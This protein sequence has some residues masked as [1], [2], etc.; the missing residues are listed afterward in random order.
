M[1]TDIE[2][3]DS[4]TP[5]PIAEI[6][7]KLGVPTEKLEPYGF[8]KA[9][10]NV[11]EL[12]PKGNLILV[13]AINPTSSGEGKTTM[14]I[15]LCDA[16][17]RI[18]KKT[19]LALR[20]PSLGPVFGVK[21]GAAG[22][23]YSQVIPMEDINLHFT[24]DIHAITAANNLLS[25]MID[26]S[27]HQDNPLNIDP[28]R[29]VWNRCVDLNDRALRSVIVGLGGTP[30]GVTRQDGFN[31]TA[32]SEIMAI[33]CLSNDLKELKEKL[34]KIVVAYAH[35]NKA[36]T[37]KDLGAD[38][39][40]AILLKDALKPNLVQTL[41]GNP[42]I[43]HGGP[44]AN[45]A[46]GCNTILATKTALTYADYCVTEAGFGADLGAEKFL[47]VKCRLSGLA[48]KCVVIV[49]TVKALKLH[50]GADK[51]SLMN[52]NVEAL[53]KG[54]PNL[55]KHIENVTNVFGINCVVAINR[56][57]TDTETELNI[58]E[59]AC[60]K[61]GAPVV[62]CEVWAKGGEGGLDL[63]KKVA[64][65]VDKA[66]GK[67][68]YVYELNQT[69]ADK[70]TA[71]ATKIYG[72]KEV[73]FTA[74]AKK[75]MKTITAEGYGDLPVIIAKTQ[76]SLSDDQK[77]LGRPENF[78]VTVREVQLRAGAGFVVAVA[79][80]IMLM[81]GLPKVPAACNMTISDEGVIKGL[82]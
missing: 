46:H 64:E 67:F 72:A 29:I 27:L 68:N 5:R 66:S 19:C 65:L 14:S 24:G 75:D 53:Q 44:F 76:Y 54:L 35:D 51:N 55:T 58:I 4:V 61:L 20:E 26:N 62:P 25:A 70:I 50:G 60:E 31:I 48:P 9:K 18:G 81:P 10:I 6:A 37:A 82:F 71:I 47:D 57:S 49:A 78:T 13:T 15:G 36:V 63:A 79:G 3:A 56:F 28:K 23:G 69:I 2:I 30:D 42:A 34:G 32:A 80:D 41:E 21:G 74:K 40:L 12:N 22:G 17:N 39:A 8:Y 77:K 16:L 7:Q 1:L 59:Q 73:E 45:I 11:N 38:Q 43:I 52:E 33:L